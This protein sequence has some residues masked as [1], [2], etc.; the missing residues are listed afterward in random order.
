VSV[1]SATISCVDGGAVSLNGIRSDLYC[2]LD[3]PNGR[4]SCEFGKDK[5]RIR[6][7]P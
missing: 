4:Y 7:M 2:F 6:A 3:V 5:L 1:D